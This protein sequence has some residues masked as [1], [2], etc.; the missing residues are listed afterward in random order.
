MGQGSAGPVIDERGV[1]HQFT[2]II[3]VHLVFTRVLQQDEHNKQD[4]IQKEIHLLFF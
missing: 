4:E 3:T 2:H 1:S